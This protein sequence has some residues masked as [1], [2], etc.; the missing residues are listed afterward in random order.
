MSKKKALPAKKGSSKPKG[1]PAPHKTLKK[2]IQQTTKAAA[3]ESIS[4]IA[5]GKKV[6]DAKARKGSGNSIKSR[7][8]P[9]VLAE[10]EKDSKAGARRS[11]SDIAAIVGF[12]NKQV[13][14]FISHYEKAAY[15]AWKA[16]PKANGG[17]T[18]KAGEKATQPKKSG[19][20][21]QAKKHGKTEEPEIADIPDNE[22][23]TTSDE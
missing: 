1:K 3:A 23:E 10:F 21:T 5:A 17:E 11:V 14:K 18:S 8:V 4:D 13:V 15:E 12:D 2:T 16:L 9:A 6:V 19:G 22:E 20:K 7:L